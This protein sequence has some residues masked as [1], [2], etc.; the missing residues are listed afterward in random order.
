VEDAVSR[1]KVARLLGG[2]RG[3]PAGDRHAL[4]AAVMAIAGFAQTHAVTFAEA[5]INPLMVLDNG[6]V[7]V[8]VLL[9]LGTPARCQA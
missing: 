8:D 4:I 1:L 7:A 9:S 6:V 3:R 2:Y 5:E